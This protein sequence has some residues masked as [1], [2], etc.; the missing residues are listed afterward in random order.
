MPKTGIPDWVKE[1]PADHLYTLT[2]FENSDAGI[3]EIQMSRAEYIALK[4]HLAALRGYTVGNI[5]DRAINLDND[6][7]PGY[8]NG[9]LQQ[10]ARHLENAR[11]IYRACPELVVV[12]S[13]KL[14]RILATLSD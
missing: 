14:D 8:R 3:E 1:T 10:N 7:P 13:S 12:K 4:A 9:D 2:M 6:L 5:R 11:A